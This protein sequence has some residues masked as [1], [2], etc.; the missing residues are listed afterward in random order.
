MQGNKLTKAGKQASIKIAMPN[1]FSD[2]IAAATE[3]KTELAKVGVAVTLDQPQYA[4]YEQQIGTGSFDAAMGGFGGSGS[5]YID[6]NNALNSKYAAPL[7]TST[8]NNFERFKSP[9]VD[10][11]LASLA[12]ATGQNAQ[13]QATYKLEQIMYQQQ[14]IVLLYYGGSWGLFSTKNFTGWPSA[15]D[16]YMLPTTYNNAMLV[17]VTHLKKA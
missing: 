4:Q 13:Q 14:P 2:W 5:P 15:S 17:V 9:A 6:F 11:A 10:Q 12:A 7:G 3:V 16:S 1:N 8:I